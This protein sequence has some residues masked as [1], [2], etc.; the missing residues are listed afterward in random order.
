MENTRSI[1]ERKNRKFGMILAALPLLPLFL[2]RLAASQAVS[3]QAAGNRTTYTITDLGT[4]GGTFS[5][6]SFISRSGAVSGLSTLPGD[7]VLRSFLWAGNGMID[8]GALPGGPDSFAENVNEKLQVTGSADGAPTPG[9]GNSLCF[10]AQDGSQAQDGLV[11]RAYLWQDGVMSDLGTLGGQSSGHSWINNKSQVVGISEID[12]PDPFGAPCNRMPGSQIIRGFLWQDGVMTDIGTLGGNDSAALYINNAEQIAGASDIRLTPDPSLGY[13]PHHAF[14]WKNGVFQDL[15][16][17][18]GGTSIPEAM[19]DIG[20]VVG[21]STLPG[22]QH[23]HPFLWKKGTMRDLGTL[24]GDTDADAEA[25]NP[26]GEVVGIS[27]TETTARAFIWS[28]GV[29]SDLNTLIDPN[30]GYQLIIAQW[31]KD[32]GQIAAL[33]LVESTGEMHAVLLTPTNN[34]IRGKSVRVPM[35]ESLRNLLLRGYGHARMKFLTCGR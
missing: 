9:D 3:I 26:S 8:L 20:D 23:I 7:A 18:G 19:D 13:V 28:N 1:K 34:N 29:M 2:L 21:F 30:A 25:V 4:L 32:T 33:A 6:P 5:Y 15:G 24:P 12:A 16:T 22:E 11:S 14:L 35:T 31:L 17:L 27:A 10:G